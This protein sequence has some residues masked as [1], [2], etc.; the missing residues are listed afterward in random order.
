[1]GLVMLIAD[2]WP[3]L[4][5]RQAPPAAY[6][7]SS[8]TSVIGWL[9][10]MLATGLA[11][12]TLFRGLLVGILVVLVPGRFRV[13]PVDLPVAAP[14]VGLLFAVAHYHSFITDPLHLAISQQIYAFA[15]ALSYVWLMERYDSLLP[16]IIAHGVGNFVEVAIV[17][18]LMHTWA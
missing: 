11:E 16:P 5:E 15:W 10:M 1:M 6:D 17:M 13:G 7:I 2:Y 18:V 8:S 9:G 12:E 4:I 3:S 14:I